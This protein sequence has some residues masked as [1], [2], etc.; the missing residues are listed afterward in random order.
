MLLGHEN[1]GILKEI[2]GAEGIKLPLVGVSRRAPP[3][4]KNLLAAATEE[5]WLLLF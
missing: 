1:I 2:A 4:T 5:N 3:D